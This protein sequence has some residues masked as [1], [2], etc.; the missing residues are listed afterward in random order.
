MPRI[1]LPPPPP[2]TGGGGER[3]EEGEQ[4][5]QPEFLEWVDDWRDEPRHVLVEENAWCR[6][7]EA[8]FDAGAPCETLFHRHREDTVY[9]CVASEGS[10]GVVVNTEAVLDGDQRPVGLL[11]PAPVSFTPGL[12]FCHLN[13][14]KNRVHR[15]QTAATNRG[16]LHFVGAEVLAD[17]P[18]L[19][20]ASGS[21]LVSCA[22]DDEGAPSTPPPPRYYRREGIDHP[23]ARVYRVSVPAGGTT[24]PVDWPFCGVV[25][26][27]RGRPAASA[28]EGKPNTAGGAWWFAG[29]LSAVDI[30][31]DA[32]AEEDAELLVVEW[33]AALG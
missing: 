27:L 8:R 3:Q 6:V 28:F 2:Q 4:Q 20:A 26:V 7:Y 32:S 9:A 13:R 24:G 5:E 21:P 14:S 23:R 11:P 12:C 18:P 17:A 22:A 1:R 16:T 25:I 31:N 10:G 19:P 29:P 33:L 15:I 30:A